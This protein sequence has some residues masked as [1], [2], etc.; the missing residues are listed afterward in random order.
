MV[1]ALPVS[2][3]IAVSDLERAR[4]FYTEK[5][6]LSVTTDNSPQEI[7]CNAGKGTRV[8]LYHRPD[9]EPAA[10][11]IAGFVAADL[12]ATVAAMAARGIQ[13]EDY[14]FPGLK[15]DENHI[16]VSP[17]GT[18]SAWFKDPDGNILAVGEM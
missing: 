4:G 6:G 14:D 2:A 13:F 8:L 9:H 11:T 16:A 18:R 1:D 3:V 12:T 15:T 17:G 7:F 5:L 10:A